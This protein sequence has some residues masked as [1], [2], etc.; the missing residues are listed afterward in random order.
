MEHLF[1]G[2]VRGRPRPR[3][4]YPNVFDKPNVFGLSK[5][6]FNLCFLGRKQKSNYKKCRFL[7]LYY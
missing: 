3:S 1:R 7:M 4:I 6:L 5:K 2:L